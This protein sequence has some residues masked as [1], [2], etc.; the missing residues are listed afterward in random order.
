MLRVRLLGGLELEVDGTPL[1][2]PAGRTVRAVLSW[3]ALNPGLHR[4]ERVAARFWPEI[5]DSSARASLRSALWALR[6]ALGDESKRYLVTNREQ[7]GLAAGETWVDVLAFYELARKGS[8]E[9]AVAIARGELLS[10]VDYD[11]AEDARLAYTGELDATLETLATAAESDEDARGAIDWTR[12][13]VALDPLAEGPQRELVRLLAAAAD[14]VAALTAYARFRDRLRRDLGMAPSAEMQ[15]IAGRL[16]SAGEEKA[17]ASSLG[18][19][20][21][22][23]PGSA[24]WRPGESFPLP[25]SLEVSVRGTLVGRDGELDSLLEAWRTVKEERCCRAALVAGEAGIGKTRLAAELAA[26][27]VADG[28]VVLH[29]EA[30]EQGVIPHKPFV[31]ALQHYVRV[32]AAEEL[33][34]R[35]GFARSEL[36]SLL[37]ELE[38][39]LGAP[40]PGTGEPSGSGESLRYRLFEAVRGALAEVAGVGGAVLV[41][42]DLHWIDASGAALLRHVV[43]PPLDVPLLILC[44]YR[45]QEVDTGHPLLE[46]LDQLGRRTPVARTALAGLDTDAVAALAERRT[47]TSDHGFAARLRARTGGNPFFVEEVLRHGAGPGAIPEEVGLV[48]GRRIARLGDEAVRLLRLAAISGSEFYLEPLRRV[49]ELSGEFVAELLD[50]AARD[51]LVAELGEVDMFRFTHDLIRE[52]LLE[53]MSRAHRARVHERIGEALAGMAA[54][55]QEV[56][57]LLLAHHLL[58]A[59]PRGNVAR[60]VEAAAQAADE[61]MRKAAYAEAVELLTQALAL[62]PESDPRRARVAARRVLAFQALSHARVDGPAWVREAA[63]ASSA[64]AASDGT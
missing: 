42:D 5:L 47:G 22:P 18:V 19:P 43:A 57:S 51:G 52:A 38:R 17:P 32:S 9:E 63:G 41:V 30:D 62:M 26:R 37:P 7:V 16:R 10:G 61:A 54:A 28:A 29:G 35:P 21:V 45:P 49:S 53:G 36:R 40:E 50:D 27:V 15:A 33:A 6:R 1:P 34:A 23:R 48:L 24:S 59:G 8:C 55:G 60:A 3:L 14:P 20:R 13:R 58:A 4:R 39:R 25:P 2:P 46:T 31:D 12:R 64:P 56:P 11:W 44:T